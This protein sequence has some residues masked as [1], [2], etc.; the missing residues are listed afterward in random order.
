MSLKWSVVAEWQAVVKEGILDMVRRQS[1]DSTSTPSLLPASSKLLEPYFVNPSSRA[2]MKELGHVGRLVGVA[3]YGA[4]DRQWLA[5]T[6]DG[7]LYL[8]MGKVIQD[9]RFAAGKKELE[10]LGW[11]DT[12]A[13]LVKDLKS[14][15]KARNHPVSGSKV[16][17]LGRV[18]A[19][20]N[21]PVLATLTA[22]FSIDG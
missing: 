19:N 3:Q 9:S 7:I 15:V 1:F 20:V 10:R 5:M 13:L 22:N 21:E 14:L 4:S 12:S 16:D 17:L 6:C 8:L 2:A 18:Q 11:V